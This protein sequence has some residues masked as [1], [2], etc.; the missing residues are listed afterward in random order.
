MLVLRAGERVVSRDVACIFVVVFEHREVD[1]PQ[2]LPA[3][4][5][6]AVRLAEFRMADLQAQR[7]EA[8]VDDLRAVGREEDDVAVLRAGALEDRRD[9]CV[10]QVLDDQLQA[11]TALR[12]LVDLDPCEALRAVD[13]HEFGVAVDVAAR[14][15]P[16]FGTRSAATRPS[17][18]LAGVLNTLKST[19][20]IASVSSVNSSCTRRSG[21]SE[22]KRAIAS[23]YGIT[24]NFASS[25]RRSSS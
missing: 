6:E 12:L 20:F 4:L 9:R 24:G 7:A 25:R 21:L 15:S 19:S 23:E 10:V 18:A 22:P 2:R 16:P 11:V 3:G 13:A 8:V 5:D 14:R 17:F 1:D